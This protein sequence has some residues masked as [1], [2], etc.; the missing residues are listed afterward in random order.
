MSGE[1]QQL[2][3][4][5]QLLLH[6]SGDNDIRAAAAKLSNTVLATGQFWSGETW[7]QPNVNCHR[8]YCMKFFVIV[9][10]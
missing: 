4:L 3:Q 2:Q 7:Q 8:F 5:L 10:S 6:S 1:G 9:F